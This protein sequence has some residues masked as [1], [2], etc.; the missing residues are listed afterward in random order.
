MLGKILGSTKR[1][2]VSNDFPDSSSRAVI[3]LPKEVN[4]HEDPRKFSVPALFTPFAIFLKNHSEPDRFQGR[5]SLISEQDSKREFKQVRAMAKY[6]LHESEVLE[7]S[8]EAVKRSEHAAKIFYQKAFNLITAQKPYPLKNHNKCIGFLA[9]PKSKLVLIAISEDR[10]PLKDIE[11]RKSLCELIQRIN[12]ESNTC[13]FEL[14]VTPT[15]EQYMLLRTLSFFT[16]KESPDTSLKKAMVSKKEAIDMLTPRTRCAEVALAVAA[17]KIGRSK[18]LKPSQLGMALFG[19]GLWEVVEKRDIKFLGFEA[20][21]RNKQYIKSPPLTFYIED[22][23]KVALDR[24]DPCE[25]HCALFL[26]ELR[27]LA[28]SGTS[29]TTFSE[30]RS[31]SIFKKFK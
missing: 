10:E 12:Q 28:A 26:N 23:R 16:S 29:S 1:N 7:P 17:C 9:I 18:P 31:E 8:Q 5:E 21:K 13:V 14:V 24:W 15:R 2:H 22:K 6:I 30:P 3:G 20:S 25:N 11:L 27:A 4:A 19:A